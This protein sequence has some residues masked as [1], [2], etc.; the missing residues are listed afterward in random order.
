MFFSSTSHRCSIWELGNLGPSK[1]LE[2]GF[3]KHF[4]ICLGVWQ[5]VLCY[6][7][8]PLTILFPSSTKGT[9]IQ[10]PFLS[11]WLFQIHPHC[12]IV[13]IHITCI[14]AYFWITSDHKAL[15][16]YFGLDKHSCDEANKALLF[17]LTMKGSVFFSLILLRLTGDEGMMLSKMIH[18]NMV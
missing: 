15:Y 8:R 17:T 12:F 7:K 1:Y 5:V 4:W 2:H 11:Q 10:E 3:P 16:L 13:H 18:P 14:L 6:W 9:W